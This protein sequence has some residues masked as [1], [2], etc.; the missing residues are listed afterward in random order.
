M[1]HPPAVRHNEEELTD[2]HIPTGAGSTPD[3]ELHGPVEQGHQAGLLL[4]ECELVLY[5]L[6]RTL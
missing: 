4:L 3:E 2:E 6:S 5:F 1:E